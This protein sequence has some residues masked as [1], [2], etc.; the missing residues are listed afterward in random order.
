MPYAALYSRSSYRPAMDPAATHWLLQQSLP[1]SIFSVTCDQSMNRLFALFSRQNMLYTK[2]ITAA[3]LTSPTASTLLSRGFLPLPPASQQASS[4]SSEL[5]ATALSL[6]ASAEASWQEF[7]AFQARLTESMRRIDSLQSLIHDD[8]EETNRAQVACQVAVLI[9]SKV[10]ASNDSDYKIEKDANW[11][12]VFHFPIAHSN[13]QSYFGRSQTCW[14][15]AACFIRPQNSLEVAM[16]LKIIAQL[17]AKFAIRSGGHNANAGFS[18]IDE[19]G[20]LIDAQDLQVR[21]LNVDGSITAGSG[22]RWQDMYDFLDGHSLGAVGGRHDGVGVAGFL[23]GGKNAPISSTTSQVYNES[24]PDQ[25]AHS[26]RRHV[27][28]P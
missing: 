18:S 1:L 16:I 26:C 12:E 15:P 21:T 20:L 2:L 25:D 17:Q 4:L 22:N 9:V 13:T 6:H 14:L 10:V 5:N 24:G 8:S 11:Y 19:N 23:L 7:L 28:L 27:I 3:A